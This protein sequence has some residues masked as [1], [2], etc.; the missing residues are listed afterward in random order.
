MSPVLDS[1]YVGDRTLAH[2]VTYVDEHGNPQPAGTVVWTSSDTTIARIDA[3]T[4]AVT[5]RKRGAV[6]ITGQAQGIIGGALVVV[7]DTLDITLL[8]D[9]VY[10]LPGDTLSAP[11]TV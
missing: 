11:V 4:G 3:Q 10:V 6:V 8:L 1:V 5:G 7:S 2:R 9:T